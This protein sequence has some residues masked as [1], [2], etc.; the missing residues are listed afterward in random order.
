MSQ[1]LRVHPE[2]VREQIRQLRA[3]R[4]AWS[5]R[6]R[7]AQWI[8]IQ[9]LAVVR[10]RP[11]VVSYPGRNYPKQHLGRVEDLAEELA[12]RLEQALNILE[13]AFEEAAQLLREPLSLPNDL[14]PATAVSAS[15]EEA[16]AFIR[17]WEGGYVHDP[18]D[19]G[20]ATN[21]G[22]TQATYDRYRR[23][24]GLPPQD[25]RHI[26]EEEAEAIYRQYYW[27]ASGAGALPRPLGLVHMDTAVNMGVERAGTFLAEAQRRHPADPRAAVEAYLDLR[28]G[29]Y[30][31]LAQDPSQRKFLAGWLNRLRDLSGYA[32][33]DP[34]FQ[35]A[36]EQ[37]VLTRLAEQPDFAAIREDLQKRWGR[38]DL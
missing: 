4:V 11:V 8:A 24:H 9:M 25:V 13:T 34:A 31:E 19:R 21:M 23:D 15:F 3:W 29:R 28:L 37:K 33:G 18:D 14:L 20:G 17:K 27:E 2:R 26:T 22:I 6:L 1:V 38:Q 32:T 5:D 16:Y 12:Q 30:L 10:A 36:F 35:R 7:A